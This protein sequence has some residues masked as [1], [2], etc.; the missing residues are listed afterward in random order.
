M[1]L[2]H[3]CFFGY[4]IGCNIFLYA[5]AGYTAGVLS[6]TLYKDNIATSTLFVAAATLFYN[7]GFFV[8]NILLKGYTDFAGYIYMRILPET[9]YNSII[10]LP[11]FYMAKALERKFETGPKREL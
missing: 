2:F 4:Y 9:V 8:L 11:I 1:G 6:Q 10:S 5:M 3:D 7:F